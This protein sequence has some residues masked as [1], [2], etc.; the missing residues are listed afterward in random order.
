MKTGGPIE[1]HVNDSDMGRLNE[2]GGPM[3]YH[4]NDSDMGRL[5]EDGGADGVSRK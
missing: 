2:D 3:E 5:N 4:V 1:Y